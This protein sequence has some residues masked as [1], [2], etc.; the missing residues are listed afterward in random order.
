MRCLIDTN[1]LVSAFIWPSGIPAK[2]IRA[3]SRKPCTAYVSPH[4]LAELREVIGRKW[5]ESLRDLDAFIE[6]VLLDMVVTTK[7]IED[8]SGS[9]AM[10]DIKDIPILMDA[11][12]EDVDV[13]ISG[14]KDF[15]EAGL[16]HPIVLTPAEFCELQP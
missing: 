9:V 4:S 1:V 13:I 8:S 7:T 6:S 10:R 15:I 3:A 12:G 16:S 14:D 11:I 5:P 2:A